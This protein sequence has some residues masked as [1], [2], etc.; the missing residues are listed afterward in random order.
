[1]KTL[2]PALEA[3]FKNAQLNGHDAWKAVFVASDQGILDNYQSSWNTGLFF[4][5]MGVPRKDSTLSNMLTQVL[6]V[7]AVILI[8][9]AAKGNQKKV[10]TDPNYGMGELTQVLW[11]GLRTD[12]TMGGVVDGYGDGPGS[13]LLFE[14][15]DF[16]IPT[17]GPKGLQATALGRRH[18]FSFY[19]D[20]EEW[21]DSVCPETI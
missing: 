12:K 1:M 15:K 5:S 14:P 19:R 21:G 3:K 7:S 11:D 9:V 6:H 13:K 4:W 18:L 8:N 16:E 2:L 20:S 10:L 17:A